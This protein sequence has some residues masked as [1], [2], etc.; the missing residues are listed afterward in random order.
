M[1]GILSNFAYAL[2]VTRSWLR[3]LSINFSQ[4]YNTAMTL[5][6]RQNFVSA[7]YRV[8]I[9]DIWPNFADIGVD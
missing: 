4:I 5:D 8:G 9:D 2:T 6:Y 3:L 1:D 7:Q